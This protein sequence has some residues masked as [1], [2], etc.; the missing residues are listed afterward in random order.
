[1]M[2]FNRETQSE[3][4]KAKPESDL[5]YDSD[6]YSDFDSTEERGLWD[7]KCVMKKIVM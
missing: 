3:D 4:W 2:T 1:M 7:I 6:D 5:G